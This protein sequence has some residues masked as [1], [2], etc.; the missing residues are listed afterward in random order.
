MH[1]NAAPPAHIVKQHLV[2]LMSVGGGS[3]AQAKHGLLM[4][5]KDHIEPVF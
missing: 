1:T 2:C 4:C 3:G 5:M